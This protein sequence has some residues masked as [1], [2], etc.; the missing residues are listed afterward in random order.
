MPTGSVAAGAFQDDENPGAAAPRPPP[1]GV[2]AWAPGAAQ[3]LKVSDLEKLIH[4]FASLDR[5]DPL[6][7]T[8]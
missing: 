3:T 5:G 7:D 8:W 4:E 1:P 6:D 2:I